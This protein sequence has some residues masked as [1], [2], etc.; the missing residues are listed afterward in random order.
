MQIILFSLA[1]S[2]LF[3]LYSKFLLHRHMQ[4]PLLVL[5]ALACLHWFI[6]ALPRWKWDAVLHP[7]QACRRHVGTYGWEAWGTHQLEFKMKK[8]IWSLKKAKHGKMKTSRK[9]MLFELVSTTP[10]HLIIFFCAKDLSSWTNEGVFSPSH[11]SMFLFIRIIRTKCFNS[12]PHIPLTRLSK[13][14]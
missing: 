7:T 5:A 1:F 4:T 11:T 3:T 8:Q 12:I 6:T 13:V 14:A 10:S 2:F 9:Q